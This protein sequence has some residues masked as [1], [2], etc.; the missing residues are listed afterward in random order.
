MPPSV[1]RRVRA[2]WLGTAMLLDAR[3]GA[4][5]RETGARKALG[6]VSTS[7]QYLF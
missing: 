4:F 7:V 1:R 2:V 3:P 6:F 5:L